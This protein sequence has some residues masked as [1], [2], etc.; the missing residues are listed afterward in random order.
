M[1]FGPGET[2]FLAACVFFAGVVD[3]LA[4]GGGLITLPA[5]LAVGLNP[6]L[7]LGTNKLVSSLGTIVST[8]RYQRALKF[9]IAPFL[10]V[11]A[12]SVVGSWL[13]ARAALLVDPSWI[14]PLLLVDLPIVAWLVWSRRDFGSSDDS[15]RLSA[16][17]RETSACATKVRR[18]S[19]PI[20]ARV[21]SAP[22]RFW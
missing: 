14:R 20:S 9:P 1:P 21:A 5:Y 13:G 6:A 10:P 3:A 22:S 11:I 2:L 12:S 16:A 7:I 4:G 19:L 17:E 8:V 15:G 18:P